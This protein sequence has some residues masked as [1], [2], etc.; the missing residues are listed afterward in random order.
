MTTIQHALEIILKIEINKSLLMYNIL[1]KDIDIEKV[2]EFY[3]I[4]FETKLLIKIVIIL[5]I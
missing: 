4:Y 1:S 3:N 5:F 2:Y